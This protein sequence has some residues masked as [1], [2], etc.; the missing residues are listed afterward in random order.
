MQRVITVSLNRNPYSV[1]ED[2]HARLQEYLTEATRTLA[3]DPD[4]S[5][6]L[7]DLEQAIADQCKR[8][9]PPHQ[10]VITQSELRPALEEIGVVQAPGVSAT[11]AG[12]DKE[13]GEHLQQISEG[14]YLSGVCLGLARYSGTEV[15]LVRV[16]AVLLLFVSGGTA[17]LLYMV[18]MLLL[19]FAAP[20]PN[21]PAPRKI[22]AK[23]REL[24][25]WVR[26]RLS[27]LTN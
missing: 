23:C 4:C 26:A 27:A 24:V 22:P 3:G 6:I 16:L 2:A 7:L 5:E 8:R 19:P 12:P 11:A 17:T 9:L 15:T 14:A 1:E 25:V 18:L 10:S 13:P 20:L 21:A